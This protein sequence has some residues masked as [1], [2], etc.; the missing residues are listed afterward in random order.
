MKTKTPKKEYQTIK[1]F[2]ETLTDLRIIK[3][4]TGQDISEFIADCAKKKNK[5]EK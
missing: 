3:A 4:H 5:W 1:I 2:K